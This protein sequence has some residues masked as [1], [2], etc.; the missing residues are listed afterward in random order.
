MT[1]VRKGAKAEEALRLYFQSLGYYA[2]RSVPFK[3]E[4]F[5]VTDLDIWLYQRTS[6][7]A[8]ERVNVDVKNKKTP[9]AIERIFWTKG[10]QT[11]LGYE[12][13]IVVTTDTRRATTDFGQKIDVL[14]LDGAF[15]KN[16]INHYEG[17]IERLSEENFSE[18]MN[19]GLVLDSRKTLKNI[20]IQQKR[21]LISDLNFNG[22]NILIEQID[23]L[24]KE[25]LAV[26]KKSEAVT[27]LL[28]LLVSYLLISLDHASHTI[29]HIVE[30]GVRF[31]I[32]ADG[33]RYGDI[34]KKRAD[35]IIQLASR[36]IPPSPSNEIPPANQVIEAEMLRQIGEYSVEP[37][38]EFFSKPEVHR[39][40]FALAKK[41]EVRA[42]NTKLATV[43]NL[44]SEEKAIF[45]LLADYF[46]ID[47]KQL[48]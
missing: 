16:V 3:F 1:S 4:T 22:V 6:L 8:R 46:S 39:K 41:L 45:G 43:Q 13:S 7:L 15:L 11:S 29:S 5:E 21:R 37:L 19:V 24:L 28:Y 36:F 23:I 17:Q 42:F 18:A 44:E 26:G 48:I 25:Y 10:L 33:F 38:A 20:Y 14:V 12:R 31:R 2:V 35:E 34:G 47:R 30:P 40:L 27:R 9:Q 32:L